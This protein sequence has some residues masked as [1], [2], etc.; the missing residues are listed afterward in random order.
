MQEGRG[1]PAMAMGVMSGP[2]SCDWEHWLPEP[3]P[4]ALADV[5][6]AKAGQV[7]VAN[8]Q[9]SPSLQH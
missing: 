9:L 4:Q 1:I 7:V 6:S 5:A 2:C 8:C 3:L